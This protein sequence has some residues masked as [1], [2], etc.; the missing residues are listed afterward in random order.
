MSI[1]AMHDIL[2]DHV[3]NDFSV[4]LCSKA[5]AFLGKLFLQR[6]V[7]LDDAVV[8]DNNLSG[9]VAVRMCVL[10]CRTAMCSPSGM[11]D[12]I[13]AVER[14]QANHFFKVAQL[15]LGT[16]NLQAVSVAANGN[17][18]R[19]VP[20]ILQAPQAVKNDRDD[21]LL[22]YISHDSAHLETAPN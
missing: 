19:V 6:D 18:G 20:A 3:G 15:A 2:L 13:R 21:T 16:T 17:A 12:S 10:F 22:A 5:V 7:V 11:A 1:A 14:L 9:A 4:G 8:D